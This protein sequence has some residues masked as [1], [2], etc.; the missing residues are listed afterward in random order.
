MD[1]TVEV[2][3]TVFGGQEEGVRGRKNENKKLVVIGIEKKEK[4]L[5]VYMHESLKK[6]MQSV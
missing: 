4:G 2:D 5:V 1:G 3:E 6:L